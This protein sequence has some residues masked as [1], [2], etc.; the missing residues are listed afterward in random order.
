MHY[1][2]RTTQALLSAL[3]N[4]F[5]YAMPGG[6]FLAMGVVSGRLSLA[7]VGAL[8]APYHPASWALAL[9]LI[10]ASYLIGHIVAAIGNLRADFWKLLH[11]N[12]PDWLAEYPTEVN[13]R[14]LYLAHYFPDLFGEIDRRQQ[15]TELLT[16]SVAALLLGWLVF[17]IF[18]PAFADVAIGTAVFVYVEVM[19]ATSQA[20][21][22]RKAIHSAGLAIEER[23]KS[24]HDSEKAIEVNGDELRFMINAIFRAVELAKV[25]QDGQGERDAQVPQI[26]SDSDEREPSRAAPKFKSN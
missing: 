21:R 25:S 8:F 10:G 9:L 18:H 23:E 17:F 7:H 26:E 14:D 13:M 3:Q 2:R 16:S 1:Q 6:L 11:R 22:T 24:A 4:T 19:F 5:W 20:S 12:D 15:V